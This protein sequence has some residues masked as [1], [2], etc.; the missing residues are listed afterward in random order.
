MIG[1]KRHTWSELTSEEKEAAMHG[2][3][4]ELPNGFVY[5]GLNTFQRYGVTN[6]T[7]IF[8]Y[9]ESEFVFVPGDQVTLGWES[10]EHGMDDATR[11][12]LLE[13]IS[14]YDV[15]DTD[16]FL[17]DQMSPVRQAAIGAMLV[18][19]AA[20]SVGWQQVPL[21]DLP[22]LGDLEVE[23]ELAKF[24]TTTYSEYERSQHFRLVRQDEEIILYLF[25]EDLTSEQVIANIHHEG[26]GILTEEEWEY[27]YGGGCRT[28]FPW[29]D[30]FHYNMKFKHFEELVEEDGSR[31]YDLCLP[32]AFGLLF[33]GDPYQYE[34]TTR[35]G[36]LM[37]KGG[38]GGNLICG[39]SGIL[40]GYLP[41]AA[42]YR[43]PYSQELEW[44]DVVGDLRYRRIVR[45]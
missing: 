2:L 10:W 26:F 44:E 29:G 8:T 7:G 36:Q 6:E 21:Q 35:E 1:M 41:V 39:G 12:D 34:W 16:Q 40:V 28:L 13:S 20:R 24:R 25:N 30:S 33:S 19:R 22:L 5:Q 14:E 27:S 15:E 11:E 23:E 45:L 37:P 31:E 3:I 4:R 38:D 42:Y 17:R 43:D 9:K 18:E 32:N